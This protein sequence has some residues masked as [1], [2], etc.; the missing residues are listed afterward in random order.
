VNL[1]C[2]I[3]VEG[4]YDVKSL[5]MKLI[6]SILTLLIYFNSASQNFSSRFYSSPTTVNPANTGNF[7]GDFRFGFTARTIR[8][9]FSVDVNTDFFADIK[10][11]NSL[12]SEHGFAAVGIGARKEAERFYGIERAYLPLSLAYSKH[13]DE[14]GLSRLSIGFQGSFSTIRIE[15]PRLIFEDQLIRWAHTG[16]AGDPF[17]SKIVTINYVDCNA[18]VNYQG[19]I[20]EK[21]L[22]SAGIT[23][24]HANRP[25]KTLEGGS[26][27]LSPE[28]NFQSG[29]EI[30]LPQKNKLLASIILN[31]N[32]EGLNIFSL[33]SMYQLNLGTGVYN[34]RAGTFF[35]HDK[36]YGATVSPCLGLK[37]MNFNLNVLYDVAVSKKTSTGK[38]FELSLLYK[39]KLIKKVTKIN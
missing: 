32:Q 4:I 6:T 23:I 16:Y 37:F 18:G 19:F 7:I 24:F 38:A 2:C 25:Q 9:A 31:K 11:L 3:T 29:I 22:F 39:K 5:N 13:L 15:P 10:I 33:G 36:L 34:L 27:S 8:N 20:S 26:F 30:A 21:H 14:E 28:I 12:L 1:P 35:Q 17:S